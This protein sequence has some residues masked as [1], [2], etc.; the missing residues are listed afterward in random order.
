MNRSK[1]ASEDL[2]NRVKLCQ[3]EGRIFFLL[4]AAP[5]LPFSLENEN[6]KSPFNVFVRDTFELNWK[7]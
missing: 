3:N 5:N 2:F 1:S 7:L 6:A 4:M